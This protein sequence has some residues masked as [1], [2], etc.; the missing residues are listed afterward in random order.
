VIRRGASLAGHL[1]LAASVSTGGCSFL[2]VSGPK[3]VDPV[4]RER[5]GCTTS[6]ALPSIDAGLT[7]LEAVNT[8]IA[9]NRTDYDY[10]GTGTSRGTVVGIG[11]ALTTL[12][13]TSALYGFSTVD[14]CRAVDAD[15]VGPYQH[16][17]KKQ[18]KTERRADEAAEEAAVEARL[19][20]KAVD[21]A[22]DAKAAGEAAKAGQPA[23]AP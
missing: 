21:D 20:A 2:F 5:A 14:S 4:H 23:R 9:L 6:R 22:N 3:K 13:A 7:G 16:V 8:L 17:G 10:L 1:V 11:V 19:K 18:T 12:L 15:M